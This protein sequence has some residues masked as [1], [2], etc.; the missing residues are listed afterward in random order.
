MSDNIKNL[1]EPLKI[2]SAL[3]SERM[4]LEY[5][6]E[7]NPK[8]ISILDYT[9]I[10]CLEKCLKEAEE[11][12]MTIGELETAMKQ[13]ALAIRAIPEKVISVYETSHKD[14]YPDGHIEYI[15]KYKREMLIVET[16]PATAGKFITVK[17]DTT[18]SNVNFAGLP[19]Y[20]TI[21][22]A[23]AAYISNTTN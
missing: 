20:D 22:E 2:R 13:H 5:R 9:I 12:E 11:N 10:A 23:I 7:N 21:K 17:Q 6:K 4:K 14:E 15:D 3:S 8:D 19:S 16:A 1:L 18:N